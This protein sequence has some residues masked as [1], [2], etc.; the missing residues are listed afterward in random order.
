MTSESPLSRF[1]CFC[2]FESCSKQR[3]KLVARLT[4]S[5]LFGGF[6]GTSPVSRLTRVAIVDQGGVDHQF[7]AHRTQSSLLHSEHQD[8]VEEEGWCMVRQPSHKLRH[9]HITRPLRLGALDILLPE[10]HSHI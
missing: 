4:G 10:R 5:G 9:L 3:T 6:G 8:E 7:V 2:E 1:Y